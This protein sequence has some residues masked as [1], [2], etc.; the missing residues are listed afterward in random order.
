MKRLDIYPAISGQAS[1]PTYD[2][3]VL[4]VESTNFG[5]RVGYSLHSTFKQAF[6]KAHQWHAETAGEIRVHTAGDAQ[7]PLQE[8]LSTAIAHNTR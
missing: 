2:R 4:V 5:D 6:N 8:H 1:A 7:R 3:F